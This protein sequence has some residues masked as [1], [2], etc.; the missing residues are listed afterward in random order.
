MMHPKRVELQ[1][2]LDEVMEGTFNACDVRWVVPAMAEEDEE[3]QNRKGT[4]PR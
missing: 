3:C 4:R 1:G 2:M